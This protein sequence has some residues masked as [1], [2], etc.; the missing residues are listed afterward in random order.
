MCAFLVHERF[1]N[2][3]SFWK[4]YIDVLPKEF[5][6]PVFFSSEEIEFLEGTPAKSSVDEMREQYRKE[7]ERAV[8]EVG[9]SVI[10]RSVFTFEAYL[11]AVA[12]CTSRSFT[13]DLVKDHEDART[14][15]NAILLPLMDMVNHYPKSKVTWRHGPDGI[16]LVTEAG[17]AAG[18]QALNN[19][20]PKSNEELMLGYGFCIEGNPFD[21]FH[22]KLNYTSDPMYEQKRQVLESVGLGELQHCITR[23]AMTKDLLPILR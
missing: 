12:V 18:Q 21:F 4:P 3:Q 7:Y 1:V 11:W 9:E 20:G 23:E 15:R 19:Y 13:D 22:V 8:E 5:S 2:K 10:P 6:T 16:D 14:A 17:L